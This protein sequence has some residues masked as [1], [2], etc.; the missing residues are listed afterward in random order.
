[1]SRLRQWIARAGR[2]TWNNW[3]RKAYTRASFQERLAAVERHLGDG[4]DLAPDG[5]VRIAS[6]CAGDGRDVLGVVESHPRRGDVVAWLVELDGNSVAAGA[7]HARRTGLEHRVNFLHADAT[8]FATYRNIAP[9]D[10]LLVCGVWGHV[11]LE[12]R[13]SLVRACGML[14]RSGGVVI[15]TRGV[16]R[17]T[18]RFE[19]IRQLFAGPT[20]EEVCVTITPD[21]KWAVATHRNMGP[22]SALPVGGQIFQFQT[23]AGR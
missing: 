1:M 14:C 6:M 15:W 17:G 13:A 3:P 21:A 10:V 12:E 22:A 19:A 7:V 16:R 11:P 4:L 8:S 18:A 5:P 2:S 20:W 9:A 23:T